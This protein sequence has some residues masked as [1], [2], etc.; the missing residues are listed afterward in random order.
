MKF[1]F[2][3]LLIFSFATHAQD[4]LTG[5][6]FK[7][8]PIKPQSQYLLNEESNQVTRIN[9]RGGSTI[10]SEDFSNGLNSINGVWTVDG[11]HPIWKHSFY[12]T[13]GEWSSGTPQPNTSSASNGFMLFDADSLNYITTPNY[14]DLDGELISPA[15]DLSSESSVVVEFEYYYRY[16]C[17]PDSFQMSLSV[18]PDSGATWQSYEIQHT[19]GSSAFTANPESYFI[20]ISSVAGGQSDVMLKWRWKGASHYFWVIDDIHIKQA[21][22]HEI[23]MVSSGWMSVNGG[24]PY[25]M[26]PHTQAQDF[27]SY[28]VITNQGASTDTVQFESSIGFAGS[29]FNG[30]GAHSPVPL[31][32]IDTILDTTIYW[33]SGANVN[34]YSIVNSIQYD[35]ILHD[36]FPLN[37]SDTHQIEIT[38]GLYARDPN[39]Y[40]GSGLWNGQD[41]SNPPN[42]NGFIMGNIY[43]AEQNETFNCISV[44]LTASTD[45]G[46]IIYTQ[47]YEVDSSGFTI[48][49]N[50]SGSLD[51]RVVTAADISWSPVIVPLVIPIN[52]GFGYNFE[53][54]KY[55]LVCV[56]HYGGPEALVVMN[57]SMS[58]VPT[59]PNSVFLFDNIST[60][61]SI[62]STPIIRISHDVFSCRIGT[63]NIHVDHFTELKPNPSSDQS[64]M[65]I[66]QALEGEWTL[67]VSDLNGRLVYTKNTYSN[68]QDLEVVIPTRNFENGV[69]NCIMNS[70]AGFVSKKLVV[71]H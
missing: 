4:Y 38:Q 34:T 5:S 20:N 53:A 55:Y 62:S 52:E 37:N 56:G 35:S 19:S 33:N 64:T 40:T 57:G 48:V 17:I 16:C 50:G 69:Y 43:H 24:I 42:T 22:A 32:S 1:T 12:G 25:T 67:N 63:N 9:E 23:E 28:A 36:Y 29:L 58:K 59:P 2:V 15:I 8:M 14:L 46:V 54:G 47:I 60:W 61:T 31:Y 44:G 6:L 7:N 70:E 18:S 13:S 49:Y 26:I 66:H 21:P 65:I 27:Y 71:T 45:P 30:I 68:G 51:E 3:F 39:I 10:W 41:N 11:T